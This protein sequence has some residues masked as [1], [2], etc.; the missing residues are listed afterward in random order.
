MKLKNQSKKP[1]KGKSRQTKLTREEVQLPRNL[2]NTLGK[3]QQKKIP[4]P[5]KA[6]GI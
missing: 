6:R 4:E 2:Q 5:K 3:K 1:L